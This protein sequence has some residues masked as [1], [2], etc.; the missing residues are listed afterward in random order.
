MNFLFAFIIGGA[1]C[2]LGQLLMDKCKLLPLHIVVLFV[3]LGSLF[4]A[5]GLYDM[6]VELA[7]AGALLPISSFGHSLTHAAVEEATSSGILGLT[8]G[9]FNLTSNGI[10]AAIVFAFL[11]ALAFKPKG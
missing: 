8:S 4:E 3:S 5:F 1:I 11:I 9:M 10:A 7:G 2:L 6:L